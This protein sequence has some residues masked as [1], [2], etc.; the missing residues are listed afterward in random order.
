MVPHWQDNEQTARR[1][2]GDSSKMRA[3]GMLEESTTKEETKTMIFEENE[4]RFK[5]AMAAPIS[6]KDLIEN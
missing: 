2:D 3:D 4:Y 5:L 6:S 1:K